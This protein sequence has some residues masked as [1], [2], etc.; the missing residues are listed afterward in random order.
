MFLGKGRLWPTTKR[1]PLAN[2]KKFAFDKQQK[3]HLSP[4]ITRST[5]LKVKFKTMRG[6]IAF[7]GSQ[8]ACQVVGFADYFPDYPDAQ[9]SSWVGL[10][11]TSDSWS[12]SWKTEK[13]PVAKG[14]DFQPSIS[15]AAAGGLHFKKSDFQTDMN[16]EKSFVDRC[17]EKFTSESTPVR[18]TCSWNLSCLTSS[19]AAGLKLIWSI[20]LHASSF[21]VQLLW[22]C[23]HQHQVANWWCN[24]LPNVRFQGIFDWKKHDMFQ[25]LIRF[26]L[27]HSNQTGNGRIWGDCCKNWWPK[28]LIW[29]KTVSQPAMIWSKLEITQVGVCLAVWTMLENH[30]HVCKWSESGKLESFCYQCEKKTSGTE[31]IDDK[32]Q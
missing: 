14:I 7:Q 15:W 11:A 13:E 16:T 32:W 23:C 8:S 19:P 28:V 12:T 5:W 17:V 2:S 18:K 26:A 20:C 27:M 21:W 6:T 22:S 24:K 4:W 9:H 31:N 10:S 25:F 3:I 30:L 29:F 1:S